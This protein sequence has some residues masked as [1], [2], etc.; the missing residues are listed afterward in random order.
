MPS[1]DLARLL[2]RPGYARF[3]LIVAA[4]RATSRGAA[5]AGRDPAGGAATE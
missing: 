2:R 4:S 5:S 3:F 1:S